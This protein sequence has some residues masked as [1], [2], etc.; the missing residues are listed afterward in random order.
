MSTEKVK[1]YDQEDKTKKGISPLLWLLPLL[2]LVGLLGYFLTRHRGTETT[3]VATTTD[4]IKPD[5]S[6]PQPASAFTAQKITEELTSKGQITFYENAIH[7][8]T[9]KATVLPDSAAV[10]GEVASVLKAHPDWKMRVEGHTDNAGAPDTNLTLSQERANAVIAYLGDHGVDRSKLDGKGFGE[11][12]PVA[13][14][15]SDTG[16]AQNRRV[17]LVKA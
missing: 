2:L 12:K 9:G 15:T 5:A 3:A 16:K 13:E 10:L 11:T 4:S 17:V 8:E 7:F 6:Q 1:I 14:N